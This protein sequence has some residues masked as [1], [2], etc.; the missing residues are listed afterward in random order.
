MHVGG[1]LAKEKLTPHF[2]WRCT[3]E[4][5]KLLGLVLERS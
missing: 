4:I 5:M 1:D 3:A 2:G